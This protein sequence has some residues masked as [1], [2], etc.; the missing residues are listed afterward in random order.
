MKLVISG[1]ISAGAPSKRNSGSIVRMPIPEMIAVIRKDRNK[2]SVD[3][4]RA[5][6]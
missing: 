3:S 6:R 2:L 4:R 1:S 5:R